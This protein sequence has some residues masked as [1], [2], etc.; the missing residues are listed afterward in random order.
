MKYILR[1]R[2]HTNGTVVYYAPLA[3]TARTPDHDAAK[4]FDDAVLAHTVAVALNDSR[5]KH[6]DGH[7]TVDVVIS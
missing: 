6:L 7:Y 2:P 5:C 3:P 4:R 1:L